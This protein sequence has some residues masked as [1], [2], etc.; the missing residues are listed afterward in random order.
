MTDF[1]DLVRLATA[2]IRLAVDVTAR[3]R[4]ATPGV[5]QATTTFR[6]TDAR[7][8][9]SEPTD[10]P[11]SASW[12]ATLLGGW[13]VT[14]STVDDRDFGTTDRSSGSTG[15]ADRGIISVDNNHYDVDWP[16]YI[17]ETVTVRAGG[18][19]L[20]SGGRYPF[21]AF[22][23]IWTGVVER[24]EPG[25]G[26][27]LSFRVASSA[28]SNLRPFVDEV[29]LGFG[30]SVEIAPADSLVSAATPGITVPPFYFRWVGV[31]DALP[32]TEGCLLRRGTEWGATVDPDGTLNL[33]ELGTRL[34]T[35]F[36][37]QIGVPASVVVA[38]GAESTDVYAAARGDSLASVL[39]RTVAPSFADGTLTFGRIA[40]NG[41]DHQMWEA[42]LWS[43]ALSEEEVLGIGWA[44]VVDPVS[45]AGLVEA[46]KAEERTGT[47]VLGS[48]QAIDL[49]FSGSPVWAGTL[50]GDDPESFD[51]ELVGVAKPDGFGTVYN[52]APPLVDTQ[53][54]AWQVGRAGSVVDLLQLRDHGV[55]M[56]PDETLVTKESGEISYVATSLTFVLDGASRLSFHRYVAGQQIDVSSA[57]SYDGTY[58]IA[59][60]SPDGR[61]LTITIGGG[62]TTGDLP[63]G[64]TVESTTPDY[65]Y[66]LAASSVTPVAGPE[67][68]ALTCDAQMRN[69][70][71]LAS[72]VVSLALDV[73]VSGSFAVDPEVGIYLPT[74]DQRSRL[75]IARRAAKS[76]LGWLAETRGGSWSIGSFDR[77]AGSALGAVIGSSQ[78]AVD[79]IDGLGAAVAR[80]ERIDLVQTR[81]PNAA[82]SIGYDQTQTL[83]DAGSLAGAVTGS[84]RRRW[85]TE[86]RWERFDDRVVRARWSTSTE[87]R[88]GTAITGRKWA[89]SMLE[90]ARRLFG[91]ER[92]FY[93]IV[94]AG[95]SPLLFELGDTILLEH[96]DPNLGLV[97]GVLAVVLEIVEDL[98]KD[99]WTVEAYT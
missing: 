59:A 74:G 6:F 67:G 42:A 58:T 78:Q 19:R 41:W 68:L 79:G 46:W 13:Q 33:L 15:A 27:I 14:R 73:A 91:E 30:G 22:Q 34:P 4:V 52:A 71:M 43:G 55:P 26:G 16:A 75:E 49:S 83:Q 54:N 90:V 3:P 57:G 35:G 69:A 39:S 84:R 98:G 61:R 65:S 63:S 53:G 38:V 40:G 45:D 96:P 95:A 47:D 11:A 81:I 62:L 87:I 17:F 28:A 18:A 66:D 44:P 20:P 9:Y 2:D 8:L 51:G 31:M 1:D 89:A 25:D 32:G 92:R 99:Q 60:V 93:R 23:T 37:F 88:I 82:I 50:E 64:S 85:S 77:P 94:V 29:F 56:A 5:A 72:D 86:Y 36:V 48:K 21:S 76:A 97:G 10:V 80:I 7:A 70:T 24:A 12:T